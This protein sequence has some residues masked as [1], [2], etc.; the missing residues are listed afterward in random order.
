ML[1]D[2]SYECFEL[3]SKKKRVFLETDYMYLI[4]YYKEKYGYK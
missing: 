4:N 1:N 2:S 3:P